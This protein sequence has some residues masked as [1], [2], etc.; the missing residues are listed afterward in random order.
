[1]TL[2]LHK[3]SRLP[4]WPGWAVG[5]VLGWLALV[6]VAEWVSWTLGQPLELCLFKRLTGL[7]CPT[8][9]MTRGVLAFLGGHVGLAFAYNPL[10]LGVATLASAALLARATLGVGLR[11]ELSRGEK[12]AA[13]ILAVAILAANWA[14]VILYVG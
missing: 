3:T 13:V 12:K 10:A 1:M 6:G 2:H 14:Y 7:P 8:C 4:Y 11:V 9:G 5:V